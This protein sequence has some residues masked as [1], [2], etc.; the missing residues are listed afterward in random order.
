M[1]QEVTFIE[2]ITFVATETFWIAMFILAFLFSFAVENG[3]LNR[4]LNGYRDDD[5]YDYGSK[6]YDDHY[7]DSDNNPND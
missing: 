6:D 7:T 5:Q 1:Q 2:F 3:D 4:Q